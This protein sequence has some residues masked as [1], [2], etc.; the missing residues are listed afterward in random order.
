MID[1]SEILFPYDEIRPVQDKLI[2]SVLNALADKESLIVHAPTGLGKTAATLSPCLAHAIKNNLTVFFLTSRH[3]QHQLA[4]KTLKDI[5]ERHPVEFTA[6]DII[7]RKWMC[8]QPGAEGMFANEFSEFC[9][10][11]R[12]DKTCEFYVNTRDGFKPSTRAKA[13]IDSL[14]CVSL[15]E[16]IIKKARDEGLCPY[17][18]TLLLAQKS[19]VII[20]DY[21]H[22]FHPTISESFLNRSG[23]ELSKSII[24][25]DE[26][27][28]L[29]P[30]IRELASA[31]LTSNIL[32]RAISE[33]KKFRYDETLGYLVM[34]QDALNELSAGKKP[35]SESLVQKSSLVSI[36]ERKVN[37]SQL[38]K[39][40]E[41]IAESIRESQRQSYIGSIATFLEMWKS[42]EEGYCRIINL[43][44]DQSMLRVSCLDPSIMS[45]QIID[46]S[47][48]NIIMSGTLTPTSMFRDLLGFK[49][50]TE[51]S[52]PSPFPKENRLNLIVPRTTTK[53]SSR[54]DE[55][56]ARIAEALSLMVDEVPGNT[57]MFFPS[58]FIRD[59]VYKNLSGLVTKKCFVEKPKLSKEEKADMLS[60]FSAC[61]DKGAIL[62]AVA[63]GSFSEGVDMPGDLLKCV[64]VVGLPFVQPDLEAQEL[65][66]YYDAKYNKGWD[67]GYTLPAFNKVLQSAG[68]CIRSETDKGVVV[69]LDER[70]LWPRYRQLFPQ[71]MDIAISKNPIEEISDFYKNF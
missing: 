69:F 24:I 37:F 12:E 64:I 11:M 3:T 70:F 1:K 34:L 9:R 10:K 13:F 29:A 44:G 27:H 25:V 4:V 5:R 71:D 39:D 22:I 52:Y 55:Q 7:G 60:E 62:L 45:E 33:A 51:R 54:S 21:F 32:K 16:D 30:R 42:P 46:N 65:I 48:V 41:L 6:T 2:G 43:D 50:C 36:V 35:G 57:F 40:L 28:N 19:Q 56:F 63:S 53:F 68:R 61:K 47:Y 15:S 38:A 59:Q 26:A 20:A 67:Y 18:V 49:K 14:H 8:S 23:K 58:Y 31:R 17:E 66:R